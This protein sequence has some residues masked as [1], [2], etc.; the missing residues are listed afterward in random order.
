MEENRDGFSIGENVPQ[1]SQTGHSGKVWLAGA[2]P[3]DAGLLTVKTKELMGSVDVIVYDA[4]ISA[5]ILSLISPEKEMIHVGKRSGHH[6]VPQE[7]INQILL[8]EAQKGKKVL[9]LKGGDPFIFG[10]GGEELEL[11][12]EHGIPF[13]IVPGITSAAAVPAYAGIP[14]THRDYTSSF[15]VITGHPRKDGTSRVD[16]P[17]LVNL[18]GTL[19]FLMGISSMETILKGL[20]GAGMD[21][22]TPAAVLEKGTLAAQRRVVSTIEHLAEDA[23]KAAIGTPAIIL[24]GKVCAL[25]DT[26]HWAE[27]RPLGGRQILITRPR[28]NGSRLSDRLRS[29]GAQVIELPAIDTKT[30]T[31]NPELERAMKDFGHTA[32]EEWLVFT[33]PIG[34][35]VFFEQMAE[36]KMDMRQLFRCPAEVKI[37]AIGAATEKE[38]AQHGLFADLVPEVY[39]AASLGRKLAEAAGRESRVTV[40]RASAGSEELLPPLAEAGIKAVD[41]PLYETVYETH[42][43]IREKIQSL[44]ENG[45]IDAVTF[46]S[47]STV[48]G[49]VNAVGDLDYKKIQA[50]CIGEQTAAEAEKYGMQIHVSQKASID[51]MVELILAGL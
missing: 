31:P 32:R 48:K 22:K 24:V 19:V 46:T 5:E 1:M 11:L 4:L 12:K 7:E 25:A 8:A 20:K 26:F 30:I 17:S 51:S 40:V 41:I 28:Q 33:S 49:F 29:L 16:Y 42:E 36:F 18:K 43:Q 47:A 10:R 6:M 13:E 2:G 14:V 50:V 39:C 37:A 15:H 3:G 23:E 34:V 9:R 44:F 38:L 45:E 27:D 21:P 35:R